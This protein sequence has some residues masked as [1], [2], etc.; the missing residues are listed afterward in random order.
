[1][2]LLTT[3]VAAFVLS[4]SAQAQTV[5]CALGVH[6]SWINADA[7]VSGIPATIG[8]TGYAPGLRGQCEVQN[9][10]VFGGVRLDYMHMQGDLKTLGVTNDAAADLFVGFKLNDKA[11]F[12]VTGGKARTFWNG[13]EL[14]AWQAGA[15]I[16]SKIGDTAWHGYAEYVHRFY[17][18][19]DIPGGLSL[20]ADIV[21]AGVSRSFDFKW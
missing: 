5:S 18:D 14:D 19:D 10:N 6:G 16:R 3:L 2:R 21:R 1:M 9:G 7:S 17:S 4:L 20:D 11:D 8:S 15:G 13:F 12:Y